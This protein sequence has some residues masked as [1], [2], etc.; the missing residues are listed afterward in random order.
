MWPM[1]RAHIRELKSLASGIIDGQ[2]GAYTE[3]MFLED[4]SDVLMV[5][6]YADNPT[7]AFAKFTGGFGRSSDNCWFRESYDAEKQDMVLEDI[8]GKG[9][10]EIYVEGN[11]VGM[12]FSAGRSIEIRS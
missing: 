2:K 8:T 10:V 7:D 5:L 11:V 3:E 6:E 1:D 9:S 4:Y 12:I